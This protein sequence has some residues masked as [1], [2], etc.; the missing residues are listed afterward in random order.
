[1]ADDPG[2]AFSAR[3]MDM[4][5]AS[6]VMAALSLGNRTK[7]LPSV[8]VDTWFTSDEL[9]GLVHQQPRYVAEWCAVMG[10]SRVFELRKSES[11]GTE[12]FLSAAHAKSLSGPGS[13][14][15]YFDEIPLLTKNLDEVSNSLWLCVDVRLSACCS[16]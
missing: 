7:L 5:S 11:G 6:A 1:M 14:S 10:T 13:L 16:V 15:P 3:I 4:L 2:A 8:P 12:Y 9:A